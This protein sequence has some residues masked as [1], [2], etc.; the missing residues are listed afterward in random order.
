MPDI[1]GLSSTPLENGDVKIWFGISDSALLPKDGVELYLGE[2]GDNLSLVYSQDPRTLESHSA[3]GGGPASAISYICKGLKEATKYYLEVRVPGLPPNKGS[4]TTLNKKGKSPFSFSFVS[5]TSAFDRDYMSDK[6]QNWAFKKMIKQMASDRPLAFCLHLGDNFYPGRNRR[7]YEWEMWGQI[8][9]MR[10]LKYVREAFARIPFVHTWD[11]HDHIDKS[12][13]G[14][15]HPNKTSHHR[16]IFSKIFQVPTTDENPDGIYR[17]L[18]HHGCSFYLLDTR[19]NRKKNKSSL[20]GE[21]QWNWLE[22]EMKRD[23]NQIKF[24]CTSSPVTKSSSSD[25]TRR[26]GPYKKDLQNLHRILA[27][28]QNIVILTGDIHKCR[29]Q[30]LR[31]PKCSYGSGNNQEDLPAVSVTQ[32]YSSGIGRRKDRNDGTGDS[33]W[34]SGYMTVYVEP[35]KKRIQVRR[36]GHGDGKNSR[37]WMTKGYPFEE[38]YPDHTLA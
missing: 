12:P 11:N 21:R 7:I 25:V 20:L 22:R 19:S 27:N 17:K 35:E 8:R 15:D 33:V 24:I 30:I 26:W 18:T 31:F 38:E 16:E 5:C 36:M 4:F 6:R 13:F 9:D 14:G 10:N 1:F 23:K 29:Y 37:S 3:R 28:N 2:A 34:E 32:I